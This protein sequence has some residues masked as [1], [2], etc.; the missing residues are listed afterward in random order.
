MKKAILP[1]LISLALCIGLLIGNF[2]AK[3]A[4]YAQ[5]QQEMAKSTSIFGKRLTNGKLDALMTLIQN[6][7]YENV[8]MDSIVEDVIPEILAQLDPH[9]AY[10]PAKDLQM[11]NDDLEGSFYGIGVQFN[12]QNDTVM[13]VAVINGGPCEK[14]GILP[15]DRIV[16]VN[17]SSFVGKN[18]TNE[19]VLKKL[20]GKLN[21]H[22]KV[23]IKRNGVKDILK[24]DIVRDEIPVNS[25]DVSYM[26]TPEIGYIKVSKFGATTY[27]EF[28][29]ALTSLKKKGCNKYIIDLRS[30]P[31]GYLEA[32][33]A[34]VN[35]F[36]PK[37]QLIVYTEGKAFRRQNEVAD[38]TGT[39]QNAQIA[40]L[41][42]EWSAS[43][44]EIF[45]G[46]I[47]DNDRGIIIGR[48]SFGK[49]LV[50]NQIN[51]PDSSAVRLTIA[52]YFTPSGRCIQKPFERGNAED[53]ENDIMNRYLHGEFD[54]ADSIKQNDSLQYKTIGGRTVYGGGGI[55]PDIFV[56]RDTS[57]NTAYYNKMIN[58]GY[59]YQFSFAYADRN[60]KTLQ[61]YKTWQDLTAY[62]QQQ[63]LLDE[64]AAWAEKKGVKRNP[65]SMEKSRP[66]FQNLL[67]AYICRDILGDN[68]FY[69]ILNQN[70][71]TVKRAV[72]EL[73]K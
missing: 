73:E 64:M 24:Y 13:I 46:A 22:V 29:T 58:L 14:L 21:T 11:V 47:Q 49:G 19:T 2:Y 25:V 62:L 4:D 40:V 7:Y 10:I 28:L 70:D 61:Q 23:G 34:M 50:Q 60:R 51:F 59:V 17:D 54:Q 45:A 71:L 55:M 41:I 48:R 39:C 65:Y 57:L 9:S 52:R 32:A 37:N 66:L 44:S 38:G 33:T 1:I 53:Y 56:A 5:Q 67:E 36:L 35:E 69:P 31:G 12:I 18:I 72:E 43:A 30:N 20:R 15:G 16:E 26:I 68:G 6:N 27:N 42:D 3:R 8:D 63:N